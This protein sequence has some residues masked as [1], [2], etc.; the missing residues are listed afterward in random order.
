MGRRAPSRR[1]IRR[2]KPMTWEEFL[3]IAG[4][5]VAGM[6]THLRAQGFA[7][8]GKVRLSWAPSVRRMTYRYAWKKGDLR[9]TAKDSILVGPG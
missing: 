8:V 4:F 3:D 2:V 6:D 7:R 5:D 1:R 9:V